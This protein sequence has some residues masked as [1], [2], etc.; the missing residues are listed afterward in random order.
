MSDPNAARLCVL[1]PDE[2]AGAAGAA[3]LAG[4]DVLHASDD[5]AIARA[6]V[7]LLDSACPAEH[8]VRAS[9]AARDQGVTVIL[10]ALRALSVELAACADVVLASPGV[11]SALTR[12]QLDDDAESAVEAVAELARLGPRTV[13]VG[14]P[15]AGIW[16][17]H[18]GPPERVPD[19]V[20]Q[21]QE[22]GLVFAGAFATRW[23]EH[24]A[25]GIPVDR[26]A[27][28][29][30]AWWGQAAGSIAARGQSPSRVAIV[31]LLRER[32]GGE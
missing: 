31:N 17:R 6:D 27:A 25:S 32:P 2:E 21:V 24:Q 5:A 16:L 11:V 19:V 1:E 14:A 18:L 4:A 15:R 7:L 29:D 12:R 3:A 23:A 20:T 26:L 28:F 9:A 13:V 22:L 10:V 30:A 8:V